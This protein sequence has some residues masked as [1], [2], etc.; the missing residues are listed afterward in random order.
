MAMEACARVQ[1]EEVILIN[2]IS[3]LPTQSLRNEKNGGLYVIN[4]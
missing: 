4:W 1:T 2:Y 3:Y